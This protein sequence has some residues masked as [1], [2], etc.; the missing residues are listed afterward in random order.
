MTA[1][2]RQSVLIVDDLE[3]NR[4]VLTRFLI[5]SGFD[6]TSC[7]SGP[8]A[9]ALVSQRVPDLIL[10]D[11]MMPGLSGLETLCALR[12]LHD[13][14]RLPIIMCTALDDDV[15]VISAISNGANDYVTKPINLPILRARMTLHLQQRRMMAGVVKG[16]AN[17]EQRLTDQTRRML[18]GTDIP[19]R[20]LPIPFS[21]PSAEGE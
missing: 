3:D 12:E 13:S 19:Q 6:A 17:A 15:S 1:D 11:W 20:P 7:D 4:I 9:I 10:L 8:A 14:V 21:D 18:Q 2:S 5:S 16:K